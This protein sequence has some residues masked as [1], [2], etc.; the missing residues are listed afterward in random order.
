[1]LSL[2]RSLVDRALFRTSGMFLAA[3]VRR[4]QSLAPQ[5]HAL[6]DH[7]LRREALSLRYRAQSGESTARLLPEAF[8][9]VRETSERTLGM[10]HY[11]VQIWAGVAL[12]E[13]AVVEMQTG[14]G[15]TLTATLP[16]FLHSLAGQGAH[17]ATANDYLASRDAELTRPLFKMLGSEVS[18][19]ESATPPAR[20]M[21]AYDADIT[22]GTA[23][24]FGFDFLR[25]RLRWRAATQAGCRVLDQLQGCD[26][27]QDREQ[28]Q[29]DLHF[30]L[31]DEADSLMIDEARTPLIVSSLPGMQPES[32]L[33]LYLWSAETA[34]LLEEAA[35]YDLNPETRQVVL[36]PRGRRRVRISS[37][38]E[39]L[40][41]VGLFD[42]YEHVE[43]AVM[44]D[45]FY[46]RDRH[47]VI[48]GDEVVIVDEATGRLAEGRQWRDGLHQAIQAR[49]GVEVTPPTSDAARITLQNFFGRY[50]HLAGM[51]G[52]ANNARREL[53]TI[54]GTPVL[55]VPTHRPP[56]RIQVEPRVFADESSKWQGIGE[57][58]LELVQTG[59]PVLIG[60]RSIDRSEILST[61]LDEYGIEHFVLNA[62]HV[63]REA[64]IVAGAGR[65]GRVTVATN[66][67]GRGTDILLDD[68]VRELG[69][70]HV[71]CSELHESSRIDRQLIGRCGRQGDPGSYRHYFALDDE[72]LRLGFGDAV[73]KRLATQRVKQ[74]SPQKWARLFL[75]AQRRVEGEHFRQRR[76][77]QLKEKQRLDLQE[78]MGLDPFMD[79]I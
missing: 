3:Q 14:E 37:K 1:M 54:Y 7:E 12:H 41:R 78:Q 20:R 49:E 40:N 50:Q 42:I 11:D 30:A 24:E 60:T 33:A 44:V 68:E 19:V 72:I 62:R 31:V 39:A 70:L 26:D 71:I 4:V 32:C 61:Q 15:K 52:T 57:E 18:A 48:R 77:L 64:K 6:S 75:K 35:D 76:M 46:Q 65:P 36:T 28:C 43:R 45:R 2:T 21:A 29:R 17:L 58:I 13:G 10:R 38:P 51:T 22:Y 69:G 5:F 73:A 47:F 25:D 27:S 74:R 55:V 53:H 8:A 66:M 9:L 59:R 16:L 79:A 56:Q 63:D 34:P 23:K 67:A